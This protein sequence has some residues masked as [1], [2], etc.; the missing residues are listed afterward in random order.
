[1]L[2]ICD[3]LLFPINEFSAFIFPFQLLASSFVFLHLPE[4]LFF[5]KTLFF[6]SPLMLVFLA[7]AAASSLW[8]GIAA[9]LMSAVCVAA[10]FS[11]H[12]FIELEQLIIASSVLAALAAFYGFK[13]HS[14]IRDCALA[15]SLAAASQA[16][17]ICL[18]FVLIVLFW[19]YLRRK[20]ENI[21]LKPVIFIFLPFFIAGILWS[22]IASSETGKFCFFTEWSGRLVPNLLSGAMG[23]VQTTEG[24]I[25]AVFSPGVD[26]GT[27]KALFFALKMAICSPAAWISGIFGR[28]KLLSSLF[29]PALFL[30]SGLAASFYA[31]RKNC[32]L[33]LLPVSAAYFFCLHIIMPVELRYFFP[34]WLI[35]C[36][37][38]SVCISDYAAEKLKKIKLLQEKSPMG[39]SWECSFF[40]A[41]FLPHLIIW[42]ASVLLL[43]TFPYRHYAA[44]PDKMLADH[45]DNIFLLKNPMRL[46]FP[47]AM[48]FRGQIRLFDKTEKNDLFSWK[49]RWLEF[50]A[51]SGQPGYTDG[52]SEIQF[53]VRGRIAWQDVLLRSFKAFDAGNVPEGERL[54]GSAAVL[55]MLSSGYVRSE[56]PVSGNGYNAEE[57][58]YSEKIA[59]AEAGRCSYEYEKF[60][61]AIPPWKKKLKNGVLNSSAFNYMFPER[62]ESYF[63]S[64][65]ASSCRECCVQTGELMMLSDCGFREQRLLSSKINSFVYL[66]PLYNGNNSGPACLSASPDGNNLRAA[67]NSCEQYY[68][69]ADD[70]ILKKAAE[71]PE[72]KKLDH[73]KQM[74]YVSLHLAQL[75]R[76]LGDKGKAEYYLN[77]TFRIADKY[78]LKLD[79]AEAM[80]EDLKN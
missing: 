80:R 18:P 76:R 43:I 47:N 63:K 34:A 33:L 24:N 75:Y 40:S 67:I 5:V 14:K 46:S 50:F 29:W 26:I 48:D 2:E 79:L 30:L 25:S 6:L 13:G 55:C 11:G 28:I 66:L 20:K 7:G 12:N 42:A 38:I 31:F 22:Q 56:N 4:N 51:Y 69:L 1:W 70:L 8:T 41:A 44:D 62:L 72:M 53:L 74:P 71:S 16:K 49:R 19:D 61:F 58:A 9:A 21:P 78:F 23:Q 65:T 35:M 57:Q 10:I 45:P 52:S 32:K 64:K 39:F 15:F 36:V 73:L 77:E 17:G 3:N 37:A 27:F 60:V 54:A 68:R 59:I